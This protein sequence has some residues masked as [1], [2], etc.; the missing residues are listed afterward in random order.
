MQKILKNCKGCIWHEGVQSKAPLHPII[1]TAPLELLHVDYMSIETTMVLDQ[2][3]KVV[4]IH[5]FQD[6]SAKHIMAYV[7]SNQT[8]KT[9]AKFLYKWY[10]L[11]SGALAKLLSNQ[12]AKVMSTIIWELNKCMGIQKVRTLPYHTQ[13]NG[14]GGHI[15]QTIMQMI[16]KLGKDR[17]T[18][19][20]NHL[21]E[22]VQDYSST[23]S[24]VVG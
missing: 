1:A 24:T 10:I 18:Y 15:H 11:T 3:P 20:L 17:K 19:W 14:Q 23:G 21:S 5:A 2:S 12:G 16:G 13:T 9:V 8:A 22:M 4:N 7:T 6:H